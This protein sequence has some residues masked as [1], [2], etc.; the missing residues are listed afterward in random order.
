LAHR[1]RRN[2]HHAF[3]QLRRFFRQTGRPVGEWSVMPAPGYRAS[4]RSS[5]DRWRLEITVVPERSMISNRESSRG[6][7]TM[8]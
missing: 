2:D 1:G 6:V 4:A 5:C 7:H 3:P 8:T